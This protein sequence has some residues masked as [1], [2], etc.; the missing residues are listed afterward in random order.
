MVLH[1]ADILPPLFHDYSHYYDRQEITQNGR[2]THHP[3][4][5]RGPLDMDTPW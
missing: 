1:L 4:Q 3:K 2:W 5:S